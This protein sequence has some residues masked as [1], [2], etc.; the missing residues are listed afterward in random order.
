RVAHVPL[1]EQKVDDA[2]E[3]DERPHDELTAVGAATP[4]A[5]A[6]AIALRFVAPRYGTGVSRHSHRYDKE[7]YLSPAARNMEG[8]SEGFAHLTARRVREAC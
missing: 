2:K 7:N 1:I 4:T 3:P 6:P 5:F 8:H